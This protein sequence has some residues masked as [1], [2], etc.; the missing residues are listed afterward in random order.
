[1]YEHRS[2]HFALESIPDG[3][4]FELTK[5]GESQP[6]YV[7]VTPAPITLRRGD[8]YFVP[9]HYSVHVHKDGYEPQTVEFG[10]STTANYWWNLAW[11]PLLTPWPP[12]AMLVVDPLTGAMYDLDVPTAIVLRKQ[13]ALPPNE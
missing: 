8:G 1:M 11:F 2:K 12:I 4:E 10:T 5:S 3:A 6:M 7:G 13:A 9:A